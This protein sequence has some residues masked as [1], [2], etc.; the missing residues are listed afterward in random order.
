MG[1]SQGLTSPVKG[2]V[3]GAIPR[4]PTITEANGFG[5]YYSRLGVLIYAGGA[6]LSLDWYPKLAL[7]ANSRLPEK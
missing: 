7:P 5:V 2:P 6:G 4:P 3:T 1:V